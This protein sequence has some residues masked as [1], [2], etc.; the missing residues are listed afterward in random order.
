MNRFVK[1]NMMLIIVVS[2]SSVAAIALL[3]WTAIEHSRMTA[4]INQV[5]KLRKD[6]GV[7]VSKKPAPVDENKPRIQ[8]DI[9]TY[10]KAADA[11]ER[12][13]NDPLLPALEQFIRVV[14]YNDPEKKAVRAIS[15]P[16]FKE[17]FFAAWDKVDSANVADQGIT[18]K[19]F[20]Q[21]FPNWRNAM[22]K[23]KEEAE[24]ATTEPITD[25]SVDEVFLTALGVPRTMQGKPE[26]L[27]RFMAD[28]RYKLLDMLSN[29]K[30]TVGNVDAGNFS[31]R[32]QDV[33]QPEEYPLVARNWDII[34]DIVSKI[35]EAKVKSLNGFYKRTVAGETVGDYQVYNF[36]FEVE[37]SLE[38]IRKLVSLLDQAYL[39]GNRVYVVRAVFLY[40]AEDQ[41]KQLFM[42][43]SAASGTEGQ[44]GEVG[45]MPPGMQQPGALQP[46]VMP[47]MPQPQLQGRGRGRRGNISRPMEIDRPQTEEEQ[48]AQLEEARRKWL[49]NEKKKP[50]YERMGYGNILVG[51]NNDC[52]AQIT[53]EYVILNKKQ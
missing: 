8:Q 12:A 39:A 10:S 32:Q 31:F 52:Q 45:L 25:Q 35:V 20:Q 29:G 43:V 41:A 11:I 24:K 42:P 37:G 44:N 48:R 14:Q 33:F 6:I 38:S 53:V 16:E 5:N 18:F 50:F 51:A 2:L 27:S 34:G 23:F 17:L 21:H 49:E 46:G 15:L 28:F 19:V 47:G 7:L 30:V 26:L 40:A 3:V 4:Y 9:E 22:N 36:T 1:K 13:F